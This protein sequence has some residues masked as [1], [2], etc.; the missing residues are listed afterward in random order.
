MGIRAKIMSGF[1]ILAAMLLVAGAWSIY[2]L[3]NIGISAQNILNENYKSIDAAKV[4]IEALEREDSAVLLLLLGKKEEGRDILKVADGNFQ[5]AM[6]IARGN[7][8]LPGEQN[9]VDAV[10]KAY[11]AYRKLWQPSAGTEY[12]GD[13]NLYFQEVNP[14]FLK[15][16]TAV[17]ELM[18]INHQAMY[19]TA[20]QVEARAHRATM[21]GI[22]AIASAFIFAIIF[23]FLIN[24]Y[25]ISPIVKLTAGIRTFLERGFFPDV[26]AEGMDEI[27]E[28]V[29]SVE[30]LTR[31]TKP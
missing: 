1:L 15:V 17:S 20:S 14:T 22:I 7:I 18:N 27:A 4:M 31:K 24:L 8:T 30:Q 23:S 6:E 26:R 25:V 5:K 2:E 11:A 10:D 9:Y 19:Q 16:K 12:R 13:L 21:P 3:K 28:L 29:S